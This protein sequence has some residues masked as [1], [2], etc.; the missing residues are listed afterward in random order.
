MIRSRY[1]KFSNQG[2]NDSGSTS[3]TQTSESSSYAMDMFSYNARHIEPSN[4]LPGSVSSRVSLIE[5]QKNVAVEASFHNY[6]NLPDIELTSNGNNTMK[7]S[8]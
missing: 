5:K 2:E 3:T 4:T 6:R 8:M 7:I 1:S